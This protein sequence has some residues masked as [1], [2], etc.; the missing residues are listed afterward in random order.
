MQDP[1]HTHPRDLESIETADLGNTPAA[2]WG[3]VKEG[4]GISTRDCR[5]CEI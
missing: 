4:F 3:T 1:G 2:M 5:R